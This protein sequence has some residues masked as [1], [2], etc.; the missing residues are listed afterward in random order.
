[1]IEDDNEFNKN[2]ELNGMTYNI[3]RYELIR[4]AMVLAISRG[5]ISLEELTKSNFSDE[6]KLKLITQYHCNKNLNN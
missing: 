1:M 3:T 4:T 2:V 5:E 6:D